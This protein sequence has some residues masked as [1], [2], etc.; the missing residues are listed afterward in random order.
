MIW[1]VV[2]FDF[3]TVADATRDD[4]EQRIAAL[5]DLEPVAWLRLGRD[6]DTPGITGLLTGFTD[7]A[8]LEAYRTHPDHLPVVDAIREAGVGASRVDFA[9]DDDAAGLPAG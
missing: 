3:S 7:L 2:R 8:A 1:H 9:T 5:A 4:L 6:L